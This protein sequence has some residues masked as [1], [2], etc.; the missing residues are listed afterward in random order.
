MLPN[1]LQDMALGKAKVSD[2]ITFTKSNMSRICNQKQDYELRA[3]PPL[4]RILKPLMLREFLKDLDYINAIASPKMSIIHTKCG[5]KTKPWTSKDKIRELH[6]LISKRAN[7][8]AFVTT[9]GDVDISRIDMN[10]TDLFNANKY[11][12]CNRD[13]L[14]FYGISV[15]FVPSESGSVN[16]STVNV[17]L[18]NFEQGIIET[19]RDFETFFNKFFE[20][21]NLEYGFSKLPTIEYYHTNIRNNDE[22]LKELQFLSDRGILSFSDVCLK[23]DYDY[24]E[25]MKKKAD[26]WKN[27]D[28]Q[29][30][31]IEL[32]QGTSPMLA[33]KFKQELELKNSGKADTSMSPNNEI[34]NK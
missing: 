3:L 16:N 11:E 22:L 25:Q 7:G 10:L 5:D 27:R 31:T 17:S 13:I 24:D 29:A 15:A 9:A 12:E 14:N 8:M 19:T 1:Y 33:E 6:E 23:F 28:I 18:K 4:L 2:K 20:Q 30:P 32:S 34:I 21:I 26:D